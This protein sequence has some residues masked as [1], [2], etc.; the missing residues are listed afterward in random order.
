MIVNL[1]N[2]IYK[3]LDI[4]ENFTPILPKILEYVVFALKSLKESSLLK[5]ALLVLNSI[6]HESKKNFSQYAP[7]L[8]PLLMEILTNN[9]V[10]RNNK[11]I[12]ITNIG[13]ISMKIGDV[14]I[15]FLHQVMEVLFSAA[16][17]AANK[18]DDVIKL[19]NKIKYLLIFLGR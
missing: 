14:F 8:I 9:E 17:L 18:S 16:G 5:A 4:Q 6:I 19:K 7:E 12:T 15:P 1:I 13:E 11:L 10:T 3:F 2:F